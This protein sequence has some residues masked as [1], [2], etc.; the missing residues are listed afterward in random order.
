MNPR[1]RGCGRG[2]SELGGTGGDKG[3]GKKVLYFNFNL[4]HK[5]FERT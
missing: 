5:K 3:T 2:L 4:T 1:V